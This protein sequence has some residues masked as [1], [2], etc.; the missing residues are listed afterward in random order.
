M[1][2]LRSS[3][4]LALFL[5]TSLSLLAANLG[6]V[7]AAMRERLP[8]IQALWAEGKI[9]EN[10]LGYIQARGDLSAKEQELLRAENADRKIVYQAIASSTRST[11]KQVGVQ[12]AAQISKRAARGLWLQDATGKWF[13][14]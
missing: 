13:R 7:Q 11:L 4:F 8:A 6:Q 3:F 2:Y 14:K 5:S 9:G 10:N 1:L 12:R